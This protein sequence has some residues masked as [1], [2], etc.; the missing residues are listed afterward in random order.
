MLKI[1]PLGREDNVDRYS[2]KSKPACR[3]WEVVTGMGLNDPGS[4]TIVRSVWAWHT[5]Q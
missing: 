1:F 5:R 2:K 3:E 4:S